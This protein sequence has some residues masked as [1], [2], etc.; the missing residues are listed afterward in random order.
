MKELTWLVDDMDANYLFR[1]KPFVLWQTV[2]HNKG[3][4]Y[5]VIAQ[6]PDS[7]SLN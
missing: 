6:M 7:V 2:L 5:T 1:I 3:N 4:T